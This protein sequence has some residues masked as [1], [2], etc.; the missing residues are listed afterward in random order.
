MPERPN[1]P[2]SKCGMPERASEVR[3]LPLPSMPNENIK[4]TIKDEI[5]WRIEESDFAPQTAEW[6]WALGILA[7]A[8]VVFAVLLKNYLLIVI[9]AL[10]AFIIYENK[11]KKPELIHFTLDGNGLRVGDKF[12]PYENFKSFWIYENIA[13]QK[14]ELVFRRQQNF[15]PLLTIFF[16]NEDESEIQKILNK[17]LPEKEEPESLI[18][19][20]RKRFF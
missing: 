3:I 17:H 13:G 2:H 4:I 18:D 12:Y 10:A 15:M 9:I 16:N 19:L 11:N 7:F 14:R 8:L 20:L 5:S 1:G 6:F